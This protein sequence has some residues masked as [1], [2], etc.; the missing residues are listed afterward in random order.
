MIEAGGS[1]AWP[2]LAGSGASLGGTLSSLSSW[3]VSVR[4]ISAGLHLAVCCATGWH[5]P[6]A[7]S[8]GASNNHFAAGL[9]VGGGGGGIPADSAQFSTSK[10]HRSRFCGVI[11]TDIPWLCWQYRQ[12]A[13]GIT[14]ATAH[15][16]T[17]APFTGCMQKLPGVWLVPIGKD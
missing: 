15:T 16:E 17:I 1:V 8:V 12:L 3:L 7:Q 10:H 6:G 2:W 4:L 14:E 5:S 9:V 13:L 11:Q